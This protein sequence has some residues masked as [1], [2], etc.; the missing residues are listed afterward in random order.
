MNLYIWLLQHRYNDFS[1]LGCTAL[2]KL[3]LPSNLHLVVM[4]GFNVCINEDV[5]KY[6]IA[7]AF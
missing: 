2:H 3:G 7:T 5:W 6:S 4:F 1:S